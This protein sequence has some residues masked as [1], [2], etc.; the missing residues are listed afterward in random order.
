MLGER[1]QIFV[2]LLIYMGEYPPQELQGTA[3]TNNCQYY[4]LSFDSLEVMYFV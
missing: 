4:Y 2:L 3:G 1:I